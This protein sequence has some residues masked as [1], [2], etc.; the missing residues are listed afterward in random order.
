[1]DLGSW[2][3]L[4]ET[5]TSAAAD[6]VP[7]A[8]RVEVEDRV[9]Y[10]FAPGGTSTSRVGIASQRTAADLCLGSFAARVST[11]DSPVLR[12]LLGGVLGTSL[13]L[14]GYRGIVGGT[15][16]VEALAAELG[17]SL[18]T[19]EH[20]LD[21]ELTLQQLVLAT[22]QVLDDD[23]EL[24]RAGLL[25]TL[26]LG[27]PN[28]DELVQL[29][30]ILAVGNGGEVAALGAALDAFD[31]VTTAA[32]VANGDTAIEI[33][34]LALAVPGVA[35]VTARVSV[36]ERPRCLIAGSIGDAL[37]TAVVRIELADDLGLLGVVDT[38]L[39]TTVQAATATA[40]IST[41]D[42]GSPKR[43]RLDMT[44][45]A[46][47]TDLRFDLEV[48]S[49]LGGPIALTVLGTTTNESTV[50]AFDHSFPES[51]FG[52]TYQVPTPG[53]NLGAVYL[54]VPDVPLVSA[55]VDALVTSTLR[56]VL[57]ALDST[58]VTPLLQALGV[59][60]AGADVTPLRVHCSGPRL[61]G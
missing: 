9:D 56:P 8:V 29:G 20:L 40:R 26:A 43:M 19:P 2:D 7:T 31:L 33:P 27:L 46:V 48:L 21:T 58:V 39:T 41:I 52:E 30:D 60:V 47:Q 53:L 24:V 16:S 50:R 54:E 36:V 28:P 10:H 51:V 5:W 61:V 3:Q 34:G 22:A 17:T 11:E 59:T 44:T 55:V 35:Q 37:D 18:G 45:S 23:G 14:V 6:D 13:D 1:M 15:V 32:L 38:R 25:R 12:G 57:G 42:C 4:D 49:L